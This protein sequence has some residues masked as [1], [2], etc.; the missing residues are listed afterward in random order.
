MAK[1][2]TLVMTCDLHEGDSP[3]EYGE[4]EEISFALDGTA[5]EIDLC[6]EHAQQLRDAF[7][8]FVAHAEKPG[9]QSSGAGGR[10][11][12]R[13]SSRGSGSGGGAER[14]RV[15]AIRE[16]AR[17]NGHKVSERGRLSASVLQAYEAAH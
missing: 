14:D 6:G 1:K 17:E 2:M 4:V 7:S 10:R 16:W 13:G 12:A 15:Q 5:Y 9:R 3:D 8:P 11:A